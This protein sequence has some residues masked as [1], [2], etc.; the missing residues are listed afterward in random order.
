MWIITELL[1][2][3][4]FGDNKVVYC[5]SKIFFNDLPLTRLILPIKKCLCSKNGTPVFH[6]EIGQGKKI[7]LTENVSGETCTVRPL[8]QVSKFWLLISQNYCSSS[9]C[10]AKHRCQ[11]GF[12]GKGYRCI[13]TIGE[14]GKLTGYTSY[15]NMLFITFIWLH[16][17][18]FGLAFK[19]FKPCSTQQVALCSSGRISNLCAKS[20][21]FLSW[22][23]KIRHTFCTPTHTSASTKLV[24]S[25][26]N[27]TCTRFIW[28]LPSTPDKFSKIKL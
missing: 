27:F 3:T 15:L 24:N 11:T 16:I 4:L 21:D 13:P 7:L 10:P 2:H 12:T 26:K 28:A 23:R 1:W 22:V 18:P 19:S 20:S 25:I 14:R 5:T 17:K 8:R 9:P 6:K